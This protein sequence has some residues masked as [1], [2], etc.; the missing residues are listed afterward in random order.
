MYENITMKPVEIV[1][2]SGVGDSRENEGGG[3][4]N[5]IHC[6]HISKCHN[7]TPPYN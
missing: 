6:N 1:L 3:E 5:Y 4:Y 2:K 7:E